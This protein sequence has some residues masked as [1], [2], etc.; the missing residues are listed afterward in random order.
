MEREHKTLPDFNRESSPSTDSDSDR[1]SISSDNSIDTSSSSTSNSQQQ[2]QQPPAQIG[3]VVEE[4]GGEEEEEEA[5]FYCTNCG[6][7][8]STKQEQKPNQQQLQ[9]EATEPETPV[10]RKANFLI[11]KG[12]VANPSTTSK[13]TTSTTVKSGRITRKKSKQVKLLLD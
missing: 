4:G 13:P 8:C 10:S 1:S 2:K 12:A 11:R 6:K 3:S 7:I 9:S 5:W